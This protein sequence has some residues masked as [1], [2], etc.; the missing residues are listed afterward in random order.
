MDDSDKRNSQLQLQHAHL[1]ESAP[2]A[3]NTERAGRET[4]CLCVHP[5]QPVAT[6]AGLR[7][8]V[9]FDLLS[10]CRL[11][12]AD[13]LGVPACISY[14]ADGSKLYCLLKE[15]A[16]LVWSLPVWRR[17]VL[18]DLPSKGGK[19]MQH[20]LMALGA[21]VKPPV[22]FCD[23]GATAVR[24]V[25]SHNP[26]PAKGGKAFLQ[27]S[28]LKGDLKKPILALATV[29]SDPFFLLVLT[30]DGQLSG[31]SVSRASRTLVPSWQRQ[32]D[33]GIGFE[34]AALY[35]GPH[36]VVPTGAI[37]VVGTSGGTVSVME[38]GGKLQPHQVGVQHLQGEPQVTGVGYSQAGSH[39]LA[40]TK[41]QAPGT[42]H[43]HG[44]KLHAGPS[45][46]ALSVLRVSPQ[47]LG[48][49]SLGSAALGVSQPQGR[50]GGAAWSQLWGASSGGA[51][52]SSPRLASAA[53][54]P[55]AG[56][57][58]A[59]SLVEGAHSERHMGRSQG[60][61]MLSGCALR[62]CDTSDPR[63]A[64]GLPSVAV[65][66]SGLQFWAGSGDSVAKRI[67]F[68]RRLYYLDNYDLAGF[69]PHN[70][71][72][73]AV[74]PL[75]TANAG[76]AK[77]LPAGLQHSPKRLAWLI[78]FQ[79]VGSGSSEDGS[80]AGGKAATAQAGSAEFTLVFDAPIPAINWTAPGASGVF[81]GAEDEF[82]AVLDVTGTQLR[83]HAT[84]ESKGTPPPA[85]RALEVF[86][87]GAHA[88]FPGP[89]WG[90]LP[91][92]E[93]TA[94]DQGPGVVAWATKGGALAISNLT[95]G[96]ATDQGGLYSTL[97]LNTRR[98]GPLGTLA[99]TRLLQLLPGEGVVQVAWQSL[100]EASEGSVMDDSGSGKASLV[101]AVITPQRALLVSVT[102]MPLAV[103][104]A[105]AGGSQFTSCLWIGP[106]LLLTTTSFQVLQMSWNGSLLRAEVSQRHLPLLGPLL[107]GWAGLAASN[108]LPGGLWRARQEMG[109]L[110]RSYDCSSVDEHLLRTLARAGCADV[111]AMLASNE[112]AIQV[113]PRLKA[114]VSAA[115]GK[116]HDVVAS[117]TAQHQASIFFPKPWPPHSSQARRL[118]GLGRAALAY[119]Q[120]SAAQELWRLAGNWADLLPLAALQADFGT[121]R[122][123]AAAGDDEARAISAALMAASEQ[124][125]RR[126][127]VVGARA[128]PGDWRVEIE[129][130]LPDVV[131]LAG[132][133]MLAPPGAAP[134]MEVA[135]G[136]GVDEAA[137][138][139]PQMDSALLQA[140]MG[141]GQGHVKGAVLQN[142]AQRDAAAEEDDISF[143]T[144]AATGGD[145]EEDLQSVEGTDGDRSEA[146]TSV[147]TSGAAK[148]P[149]AAA[150]AAFMDAPNLDEGASSED[151]G[152]DASTKAGMGG[153]LKPSASDASFTSTSTQN[154]PPSQRFKVVIK[155]KAEAPVGDST[156]ALRAAAQGLKLAPLISLAPPSQ[157]SGSAVRPSAGPQKA[158]KFKSQ[159]SSSDEEG[160]DT[161]RPRPAVGGIRPKPVP[162]PGAKPASAAPPVFDPFPEGA[163][164]PL[165]M[166]LPPAIN[167]A[168]SSKAQAPR[169]IP[170][171]LFMATPK[172]PATPPAPAGP[173]QPAQ[174]SPPA[175]LARVDRP[176]SR[177]KP[178]SAPAAAPPA[179]PAPAASSPGLKA[180]IAA[181]EAGKWAEAASALTTVMQQRL[182]SAEMQRAAVYYSA[183]LLLQEGSRTDKQQGARLTRYVAALPL[184]IGHRRAL[185]QSAAARNMEVQNY[186]Y[187]V[188][189][190]TWLVAQSTGTAAPGYLA[191]L[192]QRIE[193]CDR[194]GG[195]NAKL[196][197]D[198]DTSSFAEIVAAAGSAADVQDCV[199][200]IVS[201]TS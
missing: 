48:E 103:A 177:G 99:P 27:G 79:V 139:I 85:L 74:A 199:R 154:V 72:A 22:Y 200:A 133:A 96:T 52:G 166:Q 89:A 110:L 64:A 159:D 92:P 16:M 194:A 4:Q 138:P 25:L 63:G 71:T 201:N 122:R 18:L 112:N 169:E 163:T 100:V 87:P 8:I 26:A 165:P 67:T 45:G 54:H 49:A 179:A 56:F 123:L 34:S 44:F 42:L 113:E 193:Q 95:S 149:Q 185:V 114:A 31:C 148:D 178:A 142:P 93:G 146:G 164:V 36:P 171:D 141:V 172:A 82:F 192:Q 191:Q 155:D 158:F 181:M 13:A 144:G 182:G 9:E 84:K 73:A 91:T 97:S 102:L 136:R 69:T 10:G 168:G 132:T 2:C 156:D 15:R 41:G 28:P 129:T 198:E 120:V 160:E 20:P 3:A 121:M 104:A 70:G 153:T 88:L 157:G 86:P 90:S 24:L 152:A 176:G 78:F 127:A 124:R 55:V 14:S 65:Q 118:V 12:G 109:R 147:A 189:Q 173:P 170:E 125:L 81:A 175:G 94:G 11:G 39:I 108:I 174:A 134:S 50:Q 83:V 61:P 62:I 143:G 190:L 29:P 77:L 111:A 23:L 6:L 1:L 57:V 137:A 151:E 188:E 184:D 126:A 135:A 140:Y 51:S 117:A 98:R 196:P 58:V 7:S 40:F 107:T 180:G 80:R 187:A 19:D 47:S 66:H 128:L 60:H 131:P 197:R 38:A 30:A 37:I 35:A 195:R 119:G 115:S 106:A 46:S 21:S 150:R 17:R 32:V 76:R 33:E 59:Q 43:A 130:D 167:V 162:S 75:P 5:R 183:V 53:V 68:Q 105:P 101:G 116:W 145:G 161:S 186:S